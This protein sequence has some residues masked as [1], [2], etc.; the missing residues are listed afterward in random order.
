[1]NA[2]TMLVWVNGM[3]SV[4]V[5]NNKG[6]VLCQG[7]SVTF[8]AAP[9]FGG[10][11]PFYIWVINGYS[12]VGGPTYIYTPSNGDIVY[13]SMMS[14][15]L[16]RTDT[17]A[18]SSSNTI[19]TVDSPI[20]PSVVINSSAGSMVG[21]GLADT[22]TAVVTNGGT[23]PLYQWVLNNSPITGATSSTYFSSGF[24]NHDSVTCMVTR[25][26]ACSLS[27]YNS[28]ILDVAKLGIKSFTGAGNI[29]VMPNPNKGT[30]ELIG[31][32]SSADGPLTLEIT[33]M[34]GQQVYS[35]IVNVK[36]G[37]INEKVELGNSP[38]SGVY[39]LNLHSGNENVVFRMVIEQ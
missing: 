22:L 11:S 23:S 17:L 29:A 26:D 31:S 6:G 36:N 32:F 2:M 12:V 4:T 27:S 3:P 15:Y 35:G 8:T 25:N 1:M 5:A 16:C 38:S 18:V 7:D 13:C 20:V 30:F 9:V 10:P 24:S 14:D 28:I 33:N 39:L 37:L 34:L 21:L 19:L